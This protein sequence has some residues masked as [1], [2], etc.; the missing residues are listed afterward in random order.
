MD[1]PLTPTPR[2]GASRQHSHS[3]SPGPRQ[4]PQHHDYPLST[5]SASGNGPMGGPGQDQVSATSSG[6]RL[7]TPASENTGKS[8]A[9]KRKNRRR[10]PRNRKQ[11]FL[12]P[13]AEPPHER[14]GSSSAVDGTRESMDGDRPNSKDGTSFFKLGRNLS[15]TSLESDA[16]LD[17]R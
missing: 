10:K 3:S 13:A 6:A 16:L 12:P 14:Q 15:N 11:S 5:D 8:K 4:R 2:L 17:H 7:Q 9:N 1:P